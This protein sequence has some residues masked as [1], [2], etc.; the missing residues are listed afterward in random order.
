[1]QAKKQLAEFMYVRLAA[2]P[3]SRRTAKQDA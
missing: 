2:L 3:E 1:M